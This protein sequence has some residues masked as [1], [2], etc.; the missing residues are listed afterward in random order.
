[1][2]N[3]ASAKQFDCVKWTRETRDR[4][5]AEIRGMSHEE[6]RRY[7]NRRPTNPILA[8]FFDRMQ[9]P[10]TLRA[11]ARAARRR[12]ASGRG[13]GARSAQPGLER[14]IRHE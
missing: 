9:A 13:T 1:M 12:A 6:M 2:M 3:E 5:N 10:E 4:I 8:K 14:H 11:S 7:F